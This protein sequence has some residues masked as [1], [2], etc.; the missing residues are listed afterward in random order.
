MQYKVEQIGTQFSDRD[1]KQ[2]EI[3][4]NRHAEQGYRFYSVFQVQKP[5]CL[6]IGTPSVIY[7]AVYIKE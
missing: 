7:L 1:V 6:S 2:L 4:L 5:G 3:H